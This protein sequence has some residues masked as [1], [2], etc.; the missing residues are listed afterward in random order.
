M[1]PRSTFPLLNCVPRH[2]PPSVGRKR[3]LS[4]VTKAF[5]THQAIHL[6][7]LHPRRCLVLI[8][9]VE[10][11]GVIGG[12]DVLGLRVNRTVDTSVC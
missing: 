4:F 6:S 2:R 10:S 7:S 5:S 11:C 9:T 12:P 8:C 1:A 3:F